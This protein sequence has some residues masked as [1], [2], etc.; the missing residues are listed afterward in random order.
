MPTPEPDDLKRLGARLDE[1]RQRDKRKEQPPPTL[2][3]IAFR[4]ST[5]LVVAVAMGG[6][7]GWGL[8]WLFGTKP[9][10]ILVMTLFG[11][12]AGFRNVIRAARE[13]NAQN[14]EAQASAPARLDDEE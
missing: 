8:D 2:P 5:E 6:A 11:I 1:V 13:L 3:G 4:F 12:A 9:I 14:V 10:F 7:M